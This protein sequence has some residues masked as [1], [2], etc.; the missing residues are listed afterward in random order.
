MGGS[1]EHIQECFRPGPFLI[2]LLLPEGSRTVPSHRREAACHDLTASALL[3]TELCQSLTC[4][5]DYLLASGSLAGQEGGPTALRVESA[6]LGP[7]SWDPG[8]LTL[9][10]GLRAHLQGDP[11]GES[12][13]RTVPGC[14]SHNCW[15]AISTLRAACA[16]DPGRVLVCGVPAFLTDWVLA[17]PLCR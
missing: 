2:L 9:L 7:S 4:A 11:E 12:W 6:Y 1:P 13:L 17:H 10:L 15:G 8:C 5:S 3:A 16:K 14:G